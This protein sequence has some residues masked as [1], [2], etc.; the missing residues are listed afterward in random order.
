MIEKT[1]ERADAGFRFHTVK[2]DKFKMSRLSFNFILPADA[3][4]SPRTR[5]MLATMMRG[6]EKYPSVV[7]INQKL[8]ELYGA[9]VTWRASSVGERHVFA[10]S[11][12]VLS[13]KY[14]FSGDEASIVKSVCD[15]IMEILFAPLLDANGLLSAS[16]FESERKLALD[17]I[18]AKINDPKSYSVE[19]CKN[20]MFKGNKAGISVEGTAEQIEKMTLREVS[21]NIEYFL[22]NAALECYYVG[23]DDVDDVIDTI[24]KKFAS[25]GR[26]RVGIIGEEK[27]FV[28]EDRANLNVLEETMNASQSRLN[29][30]CTS[31]VIMSDSDYYAICLFNEIYGGSSVAK[32]FM[33]VREKQSLCYYCYSSYGSATGVLMIGC[34][35]KSENRE[36]AY[37]EIEKQLREMQNGSFTEDDISTAKRAV[38]SG[39]LQISDSPAAIEA[40]KFRRFLAGVDESPAEVMKKI[41]AVSK[42]EIV[43]VAKKVR[44]DSVYFLCG[45]GEG[46]DDD[47]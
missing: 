20:L 26:E 31:G 32:L 44:F 24:G 4:R 30:G 12:K 37:S 11:C 46:E 25:I 42:E 35:I 14:R 5:L 22:K 27:A 23:S 16:N 1:V 10:I 43:A 21:E 39:L 18:K 45:N 15:I 36:K 9:T 3:D 41:N 47:E 8:D 28:R 29:I 7:A 17:A 6:C 13:N 2:T 33:N 19:K 34:G 38:I 40:F